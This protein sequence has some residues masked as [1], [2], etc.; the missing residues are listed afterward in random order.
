M[1]RVFKQKRK[2]GLIPALADNRN[3]VVSV[4]DDID[5]VFLLANHDPASRKLI[6]AVDEIREKQKIKPPKFNI[7]FATATFMG[8][9]L[10]S[11]N[12][13]SLEDFWQQLARI[14][15]KPV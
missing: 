4:A 10:Y 15:N 5:V 6:A 11:Q 9:G 7:C 3:E 2:M 13:L 8:F 1:L 14:A 12:V